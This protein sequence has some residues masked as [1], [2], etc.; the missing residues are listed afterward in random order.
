MAMVVREATAGNQ[1]IWKYAGRLPRYG[2][3]PISSISR[4]EYN[5]AICIAIY[6]YG[7]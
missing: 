1:E 6:I 5:I 2:L 7:Y 3:L 4:Y